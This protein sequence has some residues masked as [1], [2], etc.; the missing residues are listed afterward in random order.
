MAARLHTVRIIVAVVVVR[1]H[2]LLFLVESA[3]EPAPELV[4]TPLAHVWLRVDDP[5]RSTG[6]LV[7][8]VSIVLI[9]HLVQEIVIYQVALAVRVLLVGGDRR[10][11]VISLEADGRSV[12]AIVVVELARELG[13]ERRLLGHLLVRR[14]VLVLDRLVCVVL[15]AGLED[16]EGLLR[17]AR[18][19]E[20]WLL[21]TA[22]EFGPS[23][24]A[25][26]GSGACLG[27]AVNDGGRTKLIVAVFAHS[28]IEFLFVLVFLISVLVL[29]YLSTCRVEADFV[30]RHGALVL[31]AGLSLGH[32]AGLVLHWVDAEHVLFRLRAV[33]HGEPLGRLAVHV[34]GA[35]V[36]P[37]GIADYFGGRHDEAWS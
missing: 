22:A 21:V 36:W 23:V 6:P 18:A 29:R 1:V 12:L 26:S 9:Y 3:A 31:R 19:S 8:H 5:C 20:R 17:A 30:G 37:A 2:L 28:H 24:E 4:A 7:L 16:L 34:Q 10:R 15:V 27:D 11:D 35:E 14:L 25:G 13:S 32:R 33:H